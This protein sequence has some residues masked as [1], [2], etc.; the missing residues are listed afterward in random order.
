MGISMSDGSGFVAQNSLTFVSCYADGDLCFGTVA[1]SIGFL[2]SFK[3]L[4]FSKCLLSDSEGDSSVLCASQSD[5]NWNFSYCTVVGC[6]GHSG[7]WSR[8]DTVCRVNFCNF[9]DNCFPL[10]SGVLVVERVGLLVKSCI[11]RNNTF[12]I[13]LERFSEDTGFFIMDCV[14]SS[15]LP[16]ES[17]YLVTT[18]NLFATETATSYIA[19][20]NTG[21]CPAAARPGSG[22]IVTGLAIGFG[23]TGGLTFAAIVIALI[24]RHRRRRSAPPTEAEDTSTFRLLLEQ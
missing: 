15:V 4:T 24:V 18:N 11:F 5:G 12:G 17:Y 3:F 6:F 13:F 8:C 23:A 10:S 20:L 1:D 16:D 9:Y 22:I 2:S 21:L 19:Y 7:I 14:F